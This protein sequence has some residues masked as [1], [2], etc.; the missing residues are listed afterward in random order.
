MKTRFR[1]LGALLALA[2]FAA[3]FA[4]NVWA[5]LCPPGMGAGMGVTVE[6][7]AGAHRGMPMHH[8]E[9]VPS[10]GSDAPAPDLSHCPFA[11]AGAGGSCVAASLPSAVA[12]LT[13]APNEPSLLSA[14]S[15]S[16]PDLLLVASLYRPPRA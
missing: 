2:A 4:G 9:P 11:V 10:D 8:P 14:I 12:S 15:D 3:F 7:D 6:V 16:L 13:A 5:S 1:H